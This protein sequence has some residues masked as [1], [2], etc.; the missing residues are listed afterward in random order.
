MPARNTSPFERIART[1]GLA[2]VAAYGVSLFFPPASAHLVPPALDAGLLERLFP[3]V[4]SWW[5]AARLAALAAGMLLLLGSAGGFGE[6][7]GIDA[8]RF[9]GGSAARPPERIPVKFGAS[10]LAVAGALVVASFFAGS[11][12]RPFQFAYVA[13]LA[14]PALLFAVAS[15]PGA[16][17][18]PAPRTVDR[19]SV[20][21]TAAVIAGWFVS[22]YVLLDNSILRAADAVDMWDGVACYLAAAAP[23]FNVLRDG[24]F[25]GYSALPT[26]IHGMGLLG[27][28]DIPLDYRLLLT[29]QN[30]WLAFVSAGVAYLAVRWIAAVT[31][32]VA[33]AAFLFSPYVLARTL[34]SP[35]FVFSVYTVA[36]FALAVS[37]ADRPRGWK[38]AAFAVVAGIGACCPNL[39]L[40][41]PLAA[42]ILIA[43]G[44]KRGAFDSNFVTATAALLFVA[45]VVP[46]R[47]EIA[48]V[49]EMAS[50]WSDASLSW[51]ALESALGGQISPYLAE[52]AAVTRPRGGDV[53]IS[54]LLAPFA[55]PRTPL[56]LWG[57]ALFDPFAQIFAAVGIVFV[58]RG[59]AYSFGARAIAALFLATLLPGLASTY[60][61]PHLTR[62][63]ALAVPMALL[64]AAGFRA[65]FAAGAKRRGAAA[66]AVAAALVAVSGTVLFD[67]INPAILPASPL[68]LAFEAL[69]YG[70]GERLPAARIGE[71]IVWDEAYARM[72]IGEFGNEETQLV[73]AERLS[74]SKGPASIAFWSPG[75]EI[76]YSVSESLCAADAKT[77][78]FTI[79]DRTF[80]RDVFVATHKDAWRPRLPPARFRES[81]CSGTL[82]TERTRAA[83]AIARSNELVVSGAGAAAAAAVLREE[84]K[85]SVADVA[86]LD[87]LAARLA[88]SDA[89]LAEAAYLAGRACTT[90]RGTAPQV[91]ARA[92]HLA[93]ELPETIVDP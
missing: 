80:T 16:H 45:T 1:A 29:V 14:V 10:G 40:V 75:E 77:R 23:G 12:S 44:R 24:C 62:V 63:A 11:F 28:G 78:L 54:L 4:P 3:M 19:F 57:D 65:L 41:V 73:N 27:V 53:G 58:L 49:V 22:R 93:G 8:R 43:T 47:A 89:G 76:D 31:A 7:E 30:L 81:D 69:G 91:C 72:M 34:V 33:A 51:A 32:P 37:A 64:A 84:L 85:R 66:A 68:H 79:S 46:G 70:K 61:R 2:L 26:T 92:Y 15:R 86:L 67:R 35:P 21:A 59:L 17:G 82:E 48:R 20:L 52:A 18:H 83:R 42:A 71:E 55:T 36:L 88:T 38:T 39:I 87:A 50:A 60:D 5:I 90:A 9:C 6:F 56:R 13:A 74:N 25:S